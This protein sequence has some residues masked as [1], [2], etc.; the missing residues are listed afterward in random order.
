MRLLRCNKL[1]N[2]FYPVIIRGIS[3]FFAACMCAALSGCSG[4]REP[5]GLEQDGNLQD[6]SG[7]PAVPA[8]AKEGQG[9]ESGEGTEA[10]PEETGEIVVF[11]CG[12][13][14]NEGVYRLPAGAR[15]CDA[16]EAAGGF[17]EDA[18]TSWL[19]LASFAADGQQIRVPTAEEG[20]ELREKELSQQS[21]AAGRRDGRININTAGLQELQEI[22]GVGGVIAGRII[23]YREEHGAFTAPEEIT[24]VTGIGEVIYNKIE[25]YITVSE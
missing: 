13:V 5:L 23:A 14:V 11:V 2:Q 16:L 9:K 20:Q 8:E 18:D 10:V 7:E 21:S 1:R 19:N 4:R 17:S 24:G 22:P 15:L 25:N 3:V 12:A 6:L